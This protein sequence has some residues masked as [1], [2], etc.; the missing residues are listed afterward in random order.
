MEVCEKRE[1]VR[2]IVIVLILVN[3]GL[4]VV[5]WVPTL[6]FPSISVEADAFNSLGDFAYSG[7]FLLG[8]EVLLR[9]K[10]ESHPHGHERFEPFI[11]LMVAG[12][13]GLTGVF[14]VARAI[15]SISSPV[16]SF[17]PYLILAL[18]V[19]VVVKFW[20]SIYLKR[21]AEEVDSTALL[22]SS[23]DAKVDVLASTTALVG[24][25]GAGI[26][27]PFLDPMVGAVVSVWIFMTAFSIGR[28]NF[29]YLTGAAAPKEVINQIRE[30]LDS[31]REVLTYHD[32][33]AYYVGPEA[34]VSISI[35]LLG[36][37]G[38]D[39]VHEIEEELREEIGSI[40][41]VDAVY[42]HLEPEK[43]LVDE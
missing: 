28:R 8:F 29:R 26:G 5:K 32:L 43:Q 33:E 15:Q 37:L 42:L 14:V 2:L 3:L 23:E 13:I 27:F 11:S 16:Y 24:V 22:S 12:A 20:L 7:L 4:F 25:V 1:I 30:I 38:F 36:K 9:P 34:H 17:A 19:S 21:R 39:R 18:V 10:D 6:V 41:G 40:K 31:R 35:H